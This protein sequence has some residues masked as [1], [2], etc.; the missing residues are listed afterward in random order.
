ML[1]LAALLHD[2]GKPESWCWGKRED[3]MDMH[4][5]GHPVKSME[6]VRDEVIPC[7][8]VVGV[9]L[10][11]AEKKR[12]LYYI[13]YHDYRMSHREKHLKKHLSIASMDDFRNLML[14]QIADAKAHVQLPAVLERIRICEEWYQRVSKME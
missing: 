2:I 3:D 13:E 1:Y 7:F 12:L 11:E 6:I 4:Y 14:L 9:T 10:L 8:E 5:Y